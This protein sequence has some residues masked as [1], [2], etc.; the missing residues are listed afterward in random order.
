VRLPVL[1]QS[2]FK[3]IPM[4]DFLVLLRFY[5]VFRRWWIIFSWNVFNSVGVSSDKNWW[6]NHVLRRKA[7]TLRDKLIN[8]YTWKWN[9][10]S[11]NTWAF[12]HFVS[13]YAIYIAACSIKRHLEQLICFC[14]S[15]KEMLLKQAA[16][17]CS[18][19]LSCKIQLSKHNDLRHQYWCFLR[20]SAQEVSRMNC[21]KKNPCS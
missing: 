16:L 9:S 11:P 21:C 3:V 12:L 1:V 6:F 19:L 4:K 2:Q 7:V 18:G 10:I 5:S 20:L 13:R 14:F 8:D 15:L 17:A